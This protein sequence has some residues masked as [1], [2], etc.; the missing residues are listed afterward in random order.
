MSDPY[1]VVEPVKPVKSGGGGGVG[2]G[3]A[4]PAPVAPSTARGGDKAAGTAGSGEV[5]AGVDTA[6][7]LSEPG[8][9]GLTLLMVIGGALL[10]LAVVMGASA[11]HNRHND[12]GYA[13]GQGFLTLFNGLLHTG[14][15]VVA[16]IASAFFMKR[17]V[18]S[19]EF[20]AGRMLVTFCTLLLVTAPDFPV[21]YVGWALKWALGLGAYWLVLRVLFRK[22]IDETNIIAAA[23]LVLYL[24]YQ[25]GVWTSQQLAIFE[26]GQDALKA[27]GGA[28]KAAWMS[29]GG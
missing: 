3:S 15:G 25:T 11:A 29:V 20:A 6:R 22:S 24:L 23:H 18:G 14:T 21:G 12:L 17:K 9:P 10:V 27:A 13:F 7:P 19:V 16:V 2:E 8:F 4:G 1:E 5:E 26:K 28:A